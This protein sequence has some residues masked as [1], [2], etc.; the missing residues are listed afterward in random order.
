MAQRDP[1]PQ[2]SGK[3]IEQLRQAGIDVIE[4]I[5][6]ERAKRLNS[7][8][9]K[10]IHTGLPYVHLKLAQTLDGKIATIK[11]DSKW[12]S[13][14]DARK[15]VHQLRFKYDAVLV[16]RETLNRDNPLLNIRLID[17]GSNEK[18]PWRVIW[19]NPE[20]MN[21]DTKVL[22]DENTCKTIVLTSPVAWMA[23]SRKV[24]QL[25]K[26][27]QI[28]VIREDDLKEKLRRLGEL[29]ISSILV[30]GGG[31][32]FSSFVME[33]LYDKLSLVIC[34]KLLGLGKDGFRTS[35]VMPPVEK[36]NQGLDLLDGIFEKA[37]NQ[38]IFTA[39]GKE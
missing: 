2:V 34:P 31:Q 17:V 33:N 10:F 5:L 26:E 7:V 32:I 3:G 16:G 24:K 12:I 6:E 28:I 35:H 14:E 27:R 37:G 23:T 13:D 19:G 8:Y 30:E 39:T 21:L 25:F 29:N 1:N 22:S 18:T 15:W 4:G 36:I 38:V 9:N 20:R 11:G